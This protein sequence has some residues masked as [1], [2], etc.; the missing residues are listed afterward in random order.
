MIAFSEEQATALV[1]D[2]G[3]LKRGRELAAPAKWAA[4]G[5]TATAAWGECAGSGSQPYRTGIDLTEPAFKC[6]C[7]SRVFPC[8]HGAG[9]LLLLARQPALA[10]A[11][12]P[13]AWLAEWLEKR[14]VK[15]AGPAAKA[16]APPAPTAPTPTALAL[17]SAAP[18]PT[19]AAPSAAQQKREARMQAG[20]QELE[21]WLLDLMSAG[22]AELEKRPLAFWESQAARLVDNQLPGLAAALRELAAYPTAGAGW[23]QRLLARLGEVYLLL[24]AFQNRA[25]LGPAARAEINQQVGLTLKKDDLLAD[26]ATEILADTWVVLGQFSW[27]ENRLTARRTWLRG[28]HSARYALV[29]EY[30][31]GGQAFATPLVPGGRYAG[32]LAFYPGLLALRVAPVALAYAGRANPAAAPAGLGFGELLHGYAGALARHPWLREWPVTLTEALPTPL[33]DGTWLLHHATEPQA[34]P[35]RLPNEEAGWQLLARSGGQPLTV[36]GEWNGHTF[37]LLGSWAES[38][39]GAHNPP[40]A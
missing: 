30:S 13:P 11:G 21:T 25:A 15:G 38:H 26:P 39:S 18:A 31:F 33:P 20:A 3:T 29:L 7:P 34:L 22:L 4:L 27:D 19:P 9:L 5:R 6:S 32:E 17:G 16:G 2:P 24:R 1:T 37:R 40:A 36:F 28:Q 12:A 23:H 10:P 8:K 35:L 14:Q